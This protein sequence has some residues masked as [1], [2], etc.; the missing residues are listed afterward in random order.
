VTSPQAIIFH[1]GG[2]EDRRALVA[3]GQAP[4]D[5]FYGFLAAEAD[6]YDIAWEST[7]EDYPERFGGLRRLGERAH[8]TAC[9]AAWRP[10]AL[11]RLGDGLRQARVAVS[12]TDHFSLTLGRWGARQRQRPFLIGL[13]H[14]LSDIEARVPS[15]GRA[16]VRWYI[17]RAAAG[18]DRM[19][20]FG[21][22]D[23]RWSVARY[24]LDEAK[25]FVFGFGVD[26][27]FWSPGPARA[28]EKRV[29][30]VGS[31]LNRDYQALLE[32][33][34]AHPLRLVTRL[35]VNVPS[36][37]TGVELLRGSFDRVAITDTV[38]R[39]FYRSARCVVVAM[40]DCWQ[41]SG[42]SVTLQALACGVPVVLTAI[43]G[44]WAPDLLRDGENCLLVPPG[45]A[46]AIGAA[47]ARLD[48]DPALVQ[49]LA[50]AGRETALGHF[51]L[52]VGD[53]AARDLLAMVPGLQPAGR[54]A[55]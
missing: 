51:S 29:L 42:Y 53:R 16:Y 6:G 45:D 34:I 9:G 55:A 3:A 25:T 20:F 43:K 22:A 18:L 47:V 50:Q 39:D 26:T 54:R 12:V 33:P 27:D 41:P 23:R 46:A 38:L 10:Y 17:R 49:R 35:P 5:F 8:A 21:D 15:R 7:A 4:R 40:H 31:D 2:R 11:D 52:A 1:K 14:G 44:L 24:G 36:G 30:A 28:E 19:G 13:F 37:R 32:A 48:A